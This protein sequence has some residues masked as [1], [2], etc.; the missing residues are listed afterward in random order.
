MAIHYLPRVKEG[1]IWPD[2]L[3]HLQTK[4]SQ[5]QM[6]IT[7]D[8][9]ITL[10]LREKEAAKSCRACME[11]SMSRGWC[12]NG[13]P[14]MH[15]AAKPCSALFCW[16]CIVRAGTDWDWDQTISWQWPGNV[17]QW[18]LVSV[19]WEP[20]FRHPVGC[21]D[22]MVFVLCGAGSRLHSGTAFLHPCDSE[23]LGTKP[24]PWCLNSR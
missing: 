18:S 20:T 8:S 1:W 23:V 2:F 3:C 6:E 24:R 21:P 9:C 11:P 19:R 7:R 16:G 13:Q 14:N 4:K 15:L 5:K 22:H 17:K 12:S 10:L